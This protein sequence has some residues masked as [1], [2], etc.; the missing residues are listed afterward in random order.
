MVVTCLGRKTNYHF[1]LVLA[2]I[3]LHSIWSGLGPAFVLLILLAC[4]LVVERSAVNRMVGG[5]NPPMPVFILRP[6]PNWLKALT[7]RVSDCGFESHWTYRLQCVGIEGYEDNC[8]CLSSSGCLGSESPKGNRS[9]TVIGMYSWKT[10]PWFL[11]VLGQM[12]PT[13]SKQWFELHLGIGVL[14]RTSLRCN[15]AYQWV[16]TWR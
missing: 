7:F 1:E 15:T 5:S 3:L 8:V 2:T 4:S 13:L 9:D 11:F 16:N 10:F 12:K 14:K 6:W